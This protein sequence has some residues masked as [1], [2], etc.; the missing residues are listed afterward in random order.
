[1]R[2]LGIRGQELRHAPNIGG[3]DEGLLKSILSMKRP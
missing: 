2:F 1:M 3:G